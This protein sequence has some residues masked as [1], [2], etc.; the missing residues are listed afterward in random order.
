MK[1]DLSDNEKRL[2]SGAWVDE[3]SCANNK[4]TCIRCFGSYIIRE[5]PRSVPGTDGYY[6]KEP[7][8]PHCKCRLYFSHL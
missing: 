4:V 1:N 8:C 3:H 2:Y 6:I 5:A 7:Q